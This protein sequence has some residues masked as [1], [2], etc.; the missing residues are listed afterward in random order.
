MVVDLGNQTMRRAKT[1]Q[2]DASTQKLEDVE[3]GF[4]VK[5]PIVVRK[6]P[7]KRSSDLTSQMQ[8]KKKTKKK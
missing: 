7:K 3:E 2:G 8:K 1:V 6:N 5:V 4:V